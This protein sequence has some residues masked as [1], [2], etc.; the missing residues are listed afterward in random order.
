[1]I[2]GV[3]FAGIVFLLPE[4]LRSLVGNG[5]AA[6]C[7]PT[8]DQWL[9]RRVLRK[10]GAPLAPTVSGARFRKIPNVL[11]PVRY[12]FEKDVFAALLFN[13]LHYAVYYCYLTS[14][15]TLFADIYNLSELQVGLC[16]LCQGVACI[17]GS[18]TEGRILDRDFR[19]TAKQ[20]GIP[21][22]KSKGSQLSA[23]FPIFKARLRTVW[24]QALLVQAV[25]IAY[26][27]VLW[28][29]A[30]LAAALIL[31]FFCK[32]EILKTREKKIL[33][34]LSAASCVRCHCYL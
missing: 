7:N 34:H 23:E 19:I 10:Q 11:E 29:N 26:G 5:S 9:K 3:L 17:L 20:A 4:T 22:A 27:W 21:D 30:H 24:I 13:A 16:Y 6:Y 15:S 25:T 28:V 33:T 12:L 1:M 32:C 8:P 18:L 14:T 2:G 31:Q